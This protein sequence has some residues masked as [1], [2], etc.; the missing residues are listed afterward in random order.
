MP[1]QQPTEAI[2]NNL[3]KLLSEKGIRTLLFNLSKQ[4]RDKTSTRKYI[5]LVWGDVKNDEGTVE[6]HI[7]RHPKNRLQMTVYPEGDSGKMAITHYKI[8]ERL[9]YVTLIECSLG[10]SVSQF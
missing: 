6:G 9:G 7:G 10:L 8:I 1:T 3:W 5:A 4:F 2:I